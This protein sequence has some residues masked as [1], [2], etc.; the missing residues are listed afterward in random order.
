M[1]RV[2]CNTTTNVLNFMGALNALDRRGADEACLVVVDGEPG[3]GKTTALHWWAIQTGS[4]FL[5]AKSEWTAPWMLGELVEELG[6]VKAHSFR[7]NFT[8][9]VEELNRRL[10]N[11]HASGD[12]FAI[13]IDEA[14]HIS[15]SKALLETLR[16]LSDTVEVP[17]VMVGM[18]RIRDN[19]SRF[20]Q[21]SSRVAQYVRFNP[22]TVADVRAIADACCEAPIADDLVAYLQA[23]TKGRVREIKEAL[24]AIELAGVR[25]GEAVTVADMAGK[26]LFN[27][28]R[29]DAHIVRAS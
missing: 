18:G 4:I 11:S 29:G 27:D 9:V 19:L 28:R 23:A 17:I 10:V 20:P 15:R 21:V 13:V 25:R 14:D 3:L 26:R 12:A 1:R 6:R 16:D 7:Q 8:I 5:R 24:K 22:A 2:F